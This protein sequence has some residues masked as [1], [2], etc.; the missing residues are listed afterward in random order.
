MK[1]TTRYVLM[2][3]LTP[4]MVVATVLGVIAASYITATSL[5]DPSDDSLQ[6]RLVVYLVFLRLITILDVILPTA[7]FFAVIFGIG[8]IYRDGEM[9]A[10]L[11]AGYSERQLTR[12]VVGF[13]LIASLAAGVASNVGR[14][15]AF[16]IS[17]AAQTRA[18]AALDVDAIRAGQIVELDAGKQR[19]LAGLVDPSTRSLGDV[20]LQTDAGNATSRVVAAERLRVPTSAL[21]QPATFDRG[22]VYWLDPRGV[23]DRTL[24]FDSLTVPLG[25][26]PAPHYRR[27]AADTYDL[28]RNKE[29]P[30]VAEF[31]WR[32]AAP[33][34]TLLLALLAV[35]LSHRTRRPGTQTRM[36]LA[37][38]LYGALFGLF[39]IAHNLVEKGRIPSS[40]GIWWFYAPS[41]AMLWFL[42]TE[43]GQHW[44]L[45]PGD[46]SL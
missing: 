25:E 46:Q 36:A 40:P 17:Y 34:T 43:R 7:L 14:P 32:M 20:V 5:L 12:V 2:E 15:W 11:A 29:P 23:D 26:R 8:R 30:D 42:L 28:A 10:L 44:S 1:T 6:P 35:P 38:V 19:L 33:V 18:A 27:K 16:R 22:R 31:Q 3:I 41:L 45:V 37:I 4:F 13:A 21:D 39:A 24:E 9:V